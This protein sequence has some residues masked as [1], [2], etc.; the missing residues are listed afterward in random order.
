M[1]GRGKGAREV[2]S[3]CRV[4]AHRPHTG[5]SQ[6]PAVAFHSGG[7]SW[8]PSHYPGWCR[9]LTVDGTK[10]QAL[11]ATLPTHGTPLLAVSP[12]L[13]YLFLIAAPNVGS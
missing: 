10:A 1:R 12:A 11:K 9:P 7:C 4:F 13:P 5:Q 2:E 6:T 3:I 8:G